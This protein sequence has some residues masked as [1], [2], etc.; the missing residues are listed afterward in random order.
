MQIV[1]YSTKEYEREHLKKYNTYNY[2]LIFVEKNLSLETT[3][4]AQD[5]IGCC[6]FVTDDLSKK[7]VDRLA[8]IGIKFI[9][10]RSSGYDHIDLS[11][12]KDHNITVMRVPKYSPQSVAEFAV[13]LILVLSRKIIKAYTNGLKHNFLLDS[14]LG[15]NIHKKTIGIVGTGYIGTVFAR[16]MNGFGA[17]LLA[18]DPV[19]NKECE[20]YGVVYTSFDNLLNESDIIS[21]HCPL[22]Q[23]TFHLIDSQAISKMKD[24]VMLINTGRGGLIDTTS[25]IEHLK[26]GKIAY[27]GLDVYQKEKGLFFQNCSEQVIEDEEFLTLQSLSNVLITPHQAFFTTESIQNICQTTIENIN[28]Y[29]QGGFLN[30]VE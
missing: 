14:L 13:T 24:S 2:D 5:C 10:L 12:A 3:D 16:I 26:N 7:V 22:N 27:A 6:C 19:R 9:T 17:H 25:L 28:A 18:Y 4:L 15:F 8:E 21:L 20:Q 11:A 23:E 30:A 29:F 1:I